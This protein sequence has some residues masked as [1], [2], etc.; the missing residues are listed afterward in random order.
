MA[1]RISRAVVSALSARCSFARLI[2]DPQRTPMIQ[3][4]SLTQSGRFIRQAL[5]G[6]K[7]KKAGYQFRLPRK[8]K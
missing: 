5:M 4:F 1:L 6:Y 3:K 7:R 2:F 8:I